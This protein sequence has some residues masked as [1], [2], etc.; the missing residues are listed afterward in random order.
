MS[1]IYQAYGVN[2]VHCSDVYG[3][4]VGETNQLAA[5]PDNG[6]LL[7][8]DSQDYYGTSCAKEN[9]VESQIVTCWSN[10]T[11]CKTSSKPMK[12]LEDY[13]LQSANNAA[14]ND[15]S[16]LG[17][18]RYLES[19]PFNEIQALWQVDTHAVTTGLAHVSNLLE[20]NRASGINAAIVDLI[21]Q[22]KFESISLVALD[23]VALH[24]NAVLS[25]LR[26]RCGQSTNE[27]EDVCGQQTPRPPMDRITPRQM[28]VALLVLY[29]VASTSYLVFR[30]RPTIL[31]TLW[32][33]ACESSS[34]KD[35]REQ[36]LQPQPAT[37]GVLA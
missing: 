6:Y 35:R 24:G 13:I 26:N 14:T 7:A 33:R 18:P 25:V 36:L 12:M 28:V 16:V 4:N 17:P 29:A 10:S 34:N 37:T 21:W 5:L 19:L 2:Y 27:E 31:H 3:L 23:N 1:A 22:E 32:A 20:D 15:A 8:I 11:S 9:Y 30:G